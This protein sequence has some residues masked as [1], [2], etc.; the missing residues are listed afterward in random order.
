MKTT[1]IHVVGWP[2]DVNQRV[3]D[4]TSMTIGDGGFLEQESETKTFSER[5]LTSLASP[6]TYNVVMD[7]DWAQKDSNGE[8]EFDRFVKWFKTVHKR[9]VNPFEFPS[10]S[11]FTVNGSVKTCQYKI[12]SGLNPSKSGFSMRVTMTWKEVFTGSF[13]VKEPENT[14]QRIDVKDG[15][16][17]V[18]YYAPLSITPTI[19]DS[20][21]KYKKTTDTNFTEISIDS[22]RAYGKYAYIRFSAITDPGDYNI[23][24]SDGKSTVETVY[25]VGA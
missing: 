9:G 21:L 16:A 1:G 3:I 8:S 5:T 19:T 6:D 23:S 14:L 11:N 20:T 2:A 25:R 17:T 15:K 13:T 22:I 12:T 18:V 4:S 10:I 24:Y 7:F